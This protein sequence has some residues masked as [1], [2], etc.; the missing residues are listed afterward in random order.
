MRL[1]C[2]R[3]NLVVVVLALLIFSTQSDAQSIK[4]PGTVGVSLAQLG[5]GVDYTTLLQSNSDHSWLL[6]AGVSSLRHPREKKIH[7]DFTNSPKSFV[8]G[9]MNEAMVARVQL[10]TVY[11][12][13]GP[14]KTNRLY[15]GIGGGPSLAMVKPYYVYVQEMDKG[16]FFP[17]LRQ[18]DLDNPDVQRNIV[19]EGAWSEGLD[20]AVFRPGVHVEISLIADLD[21]TYRKQRFKTGARFDHFFY[22][23]EL[24]AKNQNRS[25][26]TYYIAYQIG[27]TGL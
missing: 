13:S 16:A 2:A 11:P 6:T 7:N 24:L 25:F 27:G 23:L 18:Q 22:D 19:A 9:K 8:Y 1:K 14:A 10:G 21:Q 20:E 3:L 12:I 15:V 17:R 4:K 26:L 5:F